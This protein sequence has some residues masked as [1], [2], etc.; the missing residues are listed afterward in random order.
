MT[1]ELNETLARIKQ[2]GPSALILNPKLNQDGKFYRTIKS[3][4]PEIK[5]IVYGKPISQSSL[6]EYEFSLE[7]TRDEESKLFELIENV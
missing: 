5:L 4:F 2:I 6:G 3:A 1:G 7:Q